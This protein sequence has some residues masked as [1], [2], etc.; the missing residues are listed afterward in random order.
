MIARSTAA[1]SNHVHLSHPHIP[2][3]MGHMRR[4]HLTLQPNITHHI[5]LR[6]IYHHLH[7]S[8]R[9]PL[10]PRDRFLNL[11]M[12]NTIHTMTPND[13]HNPSTRLYYIHLFL[14]PSTSA[15]YISYTPSTV[16]PQPTP[17]YLPNDLPS[18]PVS[19]VVF[20]PL[21]DHNDIA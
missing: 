7:M 10:I 18:Q 9:A 14:D 17:L 12:T 13:T 1:N 11:T 4:L 15:P 19:P 16:N 6:V 2:L 8:A 3:T 5:P 20:S 21:D